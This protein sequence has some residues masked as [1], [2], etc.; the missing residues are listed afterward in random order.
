[1]IEEELVDCKRSAYVGYKT[2]ISF[3]LEYLR[4][5]YRR[6]Q[7]QKGEED[8]FPQVQSWGFRRHGNSKVPYYLTMIIESGIYRRLEEY[9]RIGEYLKRRNITR[10][11]SCETKSDRIVRPLGISGSIQTVFIICSIML[12]VAFINLSGEG[13]SSEENRQLLFLNF[14]YFK[15]IKFVIF[16]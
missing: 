2:D 3:E 4:S 9:S 12:P 14:M 1:V 10:I 7:W 16:S 15:S 8:I 11:I 6:Q 5:N 13:L